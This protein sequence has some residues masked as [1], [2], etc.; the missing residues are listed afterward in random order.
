MRNTIFSFVLLLL[1]NSFATAQTAPLKK[2]HAYKETILEGKKPLNN[3]ATKGK[4]HFYIYVEILKNKKIT[5]SSIW[6]NN[7]LYICKM[8]KVLKTP[9]MNPTTG[10]KEKW[11]AVPKSANDVYE[12]QIIK[13]QEPGPRPGSTLGNYL[14]NNEI[15][16]NYQFM[17]KQ[18][19]AVLRKFKV[20]DLIQLI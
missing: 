5:I 9:V 13:K 6:I 17:G 3:E 7:E 14:Q 12:I 1:V 10:S 15:V 18:Y 16:L 20:L 2:M 4:D 11:T 8:S 19:F